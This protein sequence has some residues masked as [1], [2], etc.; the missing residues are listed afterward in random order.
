M[1]ILVAT[2]Q[3]MVS[4]AVISVWLSCFNMGLHCSAACCFAAHAWR[5]FLQ[6][7]ICYLL[8]RGITAECHSCRLSEFVL[9]S[10]IINGLNIAAM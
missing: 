4:T 5:A 7:A 10:F 6:F 8:S 1:W 3:K 2:S 9:P